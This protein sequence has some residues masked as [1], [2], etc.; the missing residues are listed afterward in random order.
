MKVCVAVRHVCRAGYH[1]V[2]TQPAPWPH[3]LGCQR[4]WVLS[5]RRPTADGYG[6]SRRRRNDTANVPPFDKGCSICGAESVRTPS[7]HLRWVACPAVVRVLERRV[8]CSARIDSVLLVMSRQCL[9]VPVQQ[10][11][12]RLAAGRIPG[13]HK[14]SPSVRVC[15]YRR[16]WSVRRHPAGMSPCTMTI[17][18]FITIVELMVFIC[19]TLTVH[20]APTT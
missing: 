9:K 10:R 20:K 14:P 18:P 3:A 13:S 6:A 4:A 7:A 2:N 15:N 8:T 11:P 1:H 12:H 17:T 16:C 19:T 5:C